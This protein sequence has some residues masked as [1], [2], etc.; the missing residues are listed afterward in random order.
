MNLDRKNLPLS[1][2]KVVELE[3][4]APSIYCKKRKLINMI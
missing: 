1:N 4:L 2:L 3:G